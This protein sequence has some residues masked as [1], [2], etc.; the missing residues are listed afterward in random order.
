MFDGPY[1][2]S[3]YTWAAS[4]IECDHDAFFNTAG[5]PFKRTLQARTDLLAPHYEEIW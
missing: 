5:L 4:C 2:E 3:Y 1:F